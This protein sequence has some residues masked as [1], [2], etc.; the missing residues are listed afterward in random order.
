MG[1]LTRVRDVASV[2]LVSLDDGFGRPV[3]YIVGTADTEQFVKNFRETWIPRVARRYPEPATA[4]RTPS[5]EMIRLLHAPE[6]M[7]VP[8]LVA[9]PA[10]LHIDLLPEWQRRSYG[11]QLMNS[12][13]AALYDRGVPAVHLGMASANTP[14]R[15]FYDRLGFHEIPVPGSG[16]LTHLGRS[17]AVATP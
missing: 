7:I 6:R 11:R 13:L 3:G 5:E 10:H 14:A 8:E 16:P 15:A 17:T 12:F 1:L 4:P 2:A 9:Y